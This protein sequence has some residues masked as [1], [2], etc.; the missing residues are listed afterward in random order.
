MAQGVGDHPLG[1]RAVAVGGA[2]PTPDEAPDFLVMED[3]QVLDEALHDETD[4]DVAFVGGD[5][6]PDLRAVA[7]GLV[8]EVLMAVAAPQG[9]H[10]LHP[11]VV[12]IG[13][14]G[15]DGL[16]ETD[17]DVE[18]P[19]VELEDGRRIEGEVGAQQD[20]ASTGGVID[21]LIWSWLDAALGAT[22]NL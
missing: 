12:G 16:L 4:L 22:P 11:E 13:A 2:Q 10:G 9:R 8:M 5:F 1:G 7:V 17:L 6:A 20:E 18:P 15:V 19:A 3:G 14:D 21:E